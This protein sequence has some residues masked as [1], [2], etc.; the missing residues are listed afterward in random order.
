M[1]A[2]F[3][4]HYY[5]HYLFKF[6]SI[7]H[8]Q[9]T[10]FNSTTYHFST[11]MFI[12]FHNFS[13]SKLINRSIEC[14][15]LGDFLFSGKFN[16]LNFSLQLYFYSYNNKCNYDIFYLFIVFATI[17]CHYTWFLEFVS[18]FLSVISSRYLVLLDYN[19]PSPYKKNPL[20]GLI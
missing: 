12:F 11:F 10:T 15:I 14:F 1:G 19:A 7:F 8:D 9:V 16:I 17:T 4:N 5:I 20:Q 3:F 2:I 13:F 6:P 18:I